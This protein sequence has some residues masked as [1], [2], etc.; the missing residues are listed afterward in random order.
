MTKKYS[1]Y[2]ISVLAIVTVLGILLMSI[3]TANAS[4]KY[5]KL[6]PKSYAK[7]CT[8]CHS[9]IP[10]LND[11][12]NKFKA[13]GRTFNF[14]AVPA[15]TTV[16]APVVPATPAYITTISKA[17]SASGHA[18][19]VEYGPDKTKWPSGRPAPNS[20][21][22]CHASEGFIDYVKTVK[23]AGG[24]K[25]VVDGSSVTIK[26]RDGY[27][28]ATAIATCDACHDNKKLRL[29][30]EVGLQNTGTLGKPGSEKP[31]MVVA[32]AGK[33]AACYACHDYRKN[34]SFPAKIDGTAAIR[35]SHAAAQTELLLGFGGAEVAGERYASSPHSA[36]PD[37]CVT[38]HMAKVAGKASHSFKPTVGACTPCHPGLTT[39]N[40]QALGDYD[41]DKSIEGIQDEVRGLIAVLKAKVGEKLGFPNAFAK[42]GGGFLVVFADLAYTDP[43]D[44]ATV[45]LSHNYI[46]DKWVPDPTKPYW[47]NPDA[48]KIFNAFYNIFLVEDEGSFGI[49][50]PAYAVQLLQQSYKDLAGT[51]VPN[52]RIR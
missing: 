47:V 23:A 48:K 17:W 8:T 19:L 43:K 11:I 10:K 4:E 24:F 44:P 21:T 5:V 31:L 51:D 30:G 29:S 25:A 35:A 27:L 39:F 40:R 22:K 49:H 14:K 41:G 33:A 9:S 2:R 34:P 13:A 37:S 42:S 6:I 32:N 45:S 46:D 26:P 20:C 12:G 36:I 52:A 3:G 28:N 18:K 38:C 16:K 15:K 50:N 7:S 1:I